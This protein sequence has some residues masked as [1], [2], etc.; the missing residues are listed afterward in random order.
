MKTFHRYLLSYLL[1]LLLPIGIL[2][3]VIF[4]IV[5]H[6]C[7]DQLLERNASALRQLNA[8]VS[9]QVAQLDAYAVQTTQR[10]EFFDRNLKRTGAFYETQRALS[11]WLMSSSFVDAVYFYG[12]GLDTVYAYNAL[13]PKGIFYERKLKGAML[14]R[15]QVERLLAGPEG[16]AWLSSLPWAQ[17]GGKL[18]YAASA[19]VSSTQRNGLIFEI[20]PSALAGLSESAMLYPQ[21]R[22]FI[23]D[24]EGNVLYASAPGADWTTEEIAGLLAQAEDMGTSRMTGATMLYARQRSERD[25]LIYLNAVPREIANAP[26]SRLWGMFFTGLLAIFALGG[27]VVALVMR[28][29]YV[30]IRRL[31]HDAM[32]AGV[33]MERSDDA[34]K[35]VRNALLAMRKNN[36]AIVRRTEAL[37]KE[38]LI[39]RLLIGGYPSAEAFNA[40]GAPLSLR[41]CGD[42]WRIVL[43]RGQGAGCEREDFAVRL[44]E[45]VRGALDAQAVQ[46]YLEVPENHSVIFLVRGDAL[47]DGARIEARLKE[48]ELNAAVRVSPPC[49]RLPELASAYTRLLRPSAA[50]RDADARQSSQ[51]MCEALRNALKFGEAERIQFTIETLNSALGGTAEGVDSRGL[52]YDVLYIVQGWFDA[53]GDAEGAR[54][55]RELL[56]LLTETADAQAGARALLREAAALLAARM[57]KKEDRENLLIRDIEDYLAENYRD[58]NFT[59]QRVADHFHLSISN[60]SH[61]FKNHAGVSVS[62]FVEGLRIRLAQE[63]LLQT[64]CSVAEIACAVGYAQSATFMR[65]FKKVCGLSP[66]AFRS[67]E[68]EARA[69]EGRESM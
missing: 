61:Y 12:T 60:L 57:Q 20:D 2:S 51:E 19:R 31:E 29:N 9:M 67:R 63:M 38:R 21:C 33:A 16:G 3:A 1:T 4:Q 48:R 46:L 43:T 35:N 34:V 17:E 50:L 30:P 5:M 54:A 26:I 56:P 15:A 28:V 62:E 22:T 37:S 42:A 59:V 55:A 58:E 11:Q 52:G 47:R 23:C 41:L 45:A 65:A 49:A 69:G 27:T 66:T 68:A 8:A 36:A 24:L 18:L 39:L 53:Q 40:D 7:G 13:Y 64:P 10:S 44:V 25:G 32:T 14:E 6:Y